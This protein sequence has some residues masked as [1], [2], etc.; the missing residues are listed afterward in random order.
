MSCKECKGKEF[1]SEIIKYRGMLSKPWMTVKDSGDRS[2]K[3]IFL[4]EAICPK[5]TASGGYKCVYIFENNIVVSVQVA[6]KKKC[7]NIR[8][9]YMKLMSV[10]GVQ[11]HLNYPG[12]IF[13]VNNYLV[14]NLPYCHMDLFT[15]LEKAPKN[16]GMIYYKD[17][18]PTLIKL[19]SKK[20]Y[21]V[22]IKPENIF[23]CGNALSFGDLD[24][25]LV[26]EEDFA[27]GRIVGTLGYAPLKFDKLFLKYNS[28]SLEINDIYALSVVICLGY[29]LS[30]LKDDQLCAIDVANGTVN[31]IIGKRLKITWDDSMFWHVNVSK[32]FINSY[33]LFRSGH[34]TYEDLVEKKNILKRVLTQKLKI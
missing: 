8:K 20:I 19:H 11:K 13:M 32:R 26:T 28:D 22:D 2:W 21:L 9:K 7:E 14:S 16:I 27:S 10:Q 34:H 6:D 5:R 4:D 17:L 18:L 15:I 30:Y 31:N 25:A 3:E 24:D 1:R 12:E 29:E 33:Y 23:V